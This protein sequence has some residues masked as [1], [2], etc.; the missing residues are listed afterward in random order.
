M[1]EILITNYPLIIQL[2]RSNLTYSEI[3]NLL[4]NVETK[5]VKFLTTNILRTYK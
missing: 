2:K 5:Y 3:K 4:A 1:E